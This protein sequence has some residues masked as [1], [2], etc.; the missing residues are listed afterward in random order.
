MDFSES[1]TIVDL[2]RIDRLRFRLLVKKYAE[3]SAIIAPKDAL[4]IRNVPTVNKLIPRNTP[5][6]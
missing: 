3:T 5:N 4:T 1:D 2:H 6:R